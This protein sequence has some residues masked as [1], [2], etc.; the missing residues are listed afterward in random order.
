MALAEGQIKVCQE[1]MAGM[2]EQNILG[3]QV[4]IY[5]T[6]EMQILQC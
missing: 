1:H 2:M 3:L 6:H 4:S 5:E